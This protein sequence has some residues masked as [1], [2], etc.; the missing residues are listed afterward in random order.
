MRI[1]QGKFTNSSGS[2]IPAY[3]VFRVSDSSVGTDGV[4]NVVA[5][6][7]DGSSS[8]YYVNQSI[9]V[10]DGK[11]GSH[12]TEE[13]IF[14]VLYDETETTP[15][16]GDLIGPQSG[17]FK[18]SSSGD[19]W[20]VVYG[21]PDSLGHVL[22]RRHHGGASSGTKILRFQIVSADPSCL[23]A[24]CTIE[25]QMFSGVAEGSTEG[26]TLLTVYDIAG[27]FFN[28][29]N[30]ELTGRMGFAA[31]MIRKN[32]KQP[33]LGGSVCDPYLDARWEVFSLCCNT[34]E[35]NT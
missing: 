21:D 19:R 6:Q 35:C 32:G 18:A 9:A 17:S 28:E 3:G 33:D 12:F 20:R 5:K 13:D 34:T 27:C 10:D 30:E 24:L 1:K 15:V 2:T 22:C 11:E 16:A 26:G 8:L 7:P 23:T 25:A 14:P 31:Y 29:P 4:V